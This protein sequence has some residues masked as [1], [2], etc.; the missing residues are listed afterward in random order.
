LLLLPDGCDIIPSLGE[1]LDCYCSYMD[2]GGNTNKQKI[3][4]D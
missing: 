4:I 2:N 1:I 3:N